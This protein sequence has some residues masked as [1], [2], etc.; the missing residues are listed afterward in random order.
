MS[1]YRAFKQI[2]NNLSGSDYIK[3]KKSKA[4]YKSY[5]RH[6]DII[7]K[8]VVVKEDGDKK[9]LA[10]AASYDMLHTIIH[11]KDITYTKSGETGTGPMSLQ[12]LKSS[13][14]VWKGSLQQSTGGV[15]STVNK[16]F[17]EELYLQSIY[18][19]NGNVGCVT[20]N[21]TDLYFSCCNDP[22]TSGT[23]SSIDKPTNSGSFSKLEMNP[24]ETKET[25]ETLSGGPS[26]V[27]SGAVCYE[28]T[29]D[30]NYVGVTAST[31]SN[32]KVEV[33]VPPTV[34]PTSSIT[35]TVTPKNKCCESGPSADINVEVIAPTQAPSLTGKSFSDMDNMRPGDTQQT[36]KSL[37]DDIFKD[38][39]SYECSVEPS[40]VGVTATISSDKVEVSISNDL[41]Q[42]YYGSNF[43]VTVTASNDV[44]S[45]NSSFRVSIYIGPYLTGTSFADIPSLDPSNTIINSVSLNEVFLMADN[46]YLYYTYA[47]TPSGLSAG[48]TVNNNQVEIDA[49]AS[50]AMGDYDVEVKATNESGSYVTASFKV[51][52]TSVLLVS[53]LQ[54]NTAIELPQPTTT[55]WYQSFTALQA[56]QLTKFAFQANGIFSTQLTVNIW[57]GEGIGTGTAEYTGNWTMDQQYWNTYTLSS[58]LN[59]ESGNKYTIQLVG[60]STENDAWW[61]S[62]YYSEN[63][64]YTGGKFVTS[65]SS[66][67]PDTADLQMKIWG[68]PAE[69][70]P[71]PTIT[72]TLSGNGDAS[73]AVI[74]EVT[75]PTGEEYV[76]YTF[77]Y[78]DTVPQTYTSSPTIQ[79]TLS[80]DFA[81]SSDTLSA[82]IFVVGGGGSGATSRIGSENYNFEYKAGTGGG[83]AGGGAYGT[84]DFT[85]SYNS[86]AV[87]VGKGGTGTVG[88]TD[89]GESGVAGDTS[90]LSIVDG[91]TTTTILETYGGGGGNCVGA[92]NTNNNSNSNG[93]CTGGSSSAVSGSL[94]ATQSY[95][96][97]VPEMSFSFTPLGNEGGISGS[98][99]GGGGGGGLGE[100]GSNGTTS[101][102]G[103]GGDG[104]QWDDVTGDYYGGGGAGVGPLGYIGIFAGNG[105]AAQGGG[106]VGGQTNTYLRNGVNGKGGGGSAGWVNNIW[107]GDG[108]SGICIIAFEKGTI[109]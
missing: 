87:E 25:S 1:N 79:G 40:S 77:A 95:P 73:Q 35:I 29:I 102:G 13:S 16:E 26:G 92:D 57:E 106:G 37:S 43:D 19:T 93:G 65:D 46:H 74:S 21:T 56:S 104:Y 33:Y 50:A 99:S 55:T 28:Y 5:S 36:V 59:L 91:D 75:S 105:I 68:L 49:S 51:T 47:I 85:S 6:P 109:Q 70:A 7:S 89:W 67:V 9:C 30:P 78:V 27:F 54:Y 44:G 64:T 88:A 60:I 8:N 90:I 22:G 61:G 20:E 69:P 76:L 62:V 86:I 58:A 17:N 83:G 31:S 81:N 14:E 80:V 53:Q 12:N 100:N 63:P 84:I 71:L 41:S 38:A 32:D 96:S 4:I 107:R 97:S 103:N 82:K 39:T 18:G 42:E 101:N 2:A 98:E 66:I 11:G 108:G 52:I 3:N 94:I 48:T 24:G 15:V 10:S 34:A 23:P 45:A 72:T